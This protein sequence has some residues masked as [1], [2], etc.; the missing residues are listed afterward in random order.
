MTFGIPYAFEDEDN[1]GVFVTCPECKA[2]IRLRAR[3]DEES[4][5]R[6]EYAQHYEEKHGNRYH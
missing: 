1:D 6:T 3:K 2:K 4:F 5:E